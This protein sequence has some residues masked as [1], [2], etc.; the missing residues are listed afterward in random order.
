M[1]F[2]IYVLAEMLQR[3]NEHV[4]GNKQV[5]LKPSFSSSTEYGMFRPAVS[6]KST[7]ASNARKQKI[8]PINK[9]KPSPLPQSP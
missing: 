1:K 4:E 9:L 5:L 7:D 6:T 2:N 3:S 8:H